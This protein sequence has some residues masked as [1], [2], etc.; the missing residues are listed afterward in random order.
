MMERLRQRR[1]ALEIALAV[2]AIVAIA[3]ALFR[4]ALYEAPKAPAAPVAASA[5][6]EPRSQEEAV[7]VYVAGSVESSDAGTGW[8]TVHVGQH[9]RVDE[10]LR[11]ALN[12]RTDLQLSD[13]SKVS[14][15]E[16]S[17]VTIRELGEKVHRFRVRR[18]RISVDYKPNAQRVL[19]VENE[20]S[21]AVAETSG[22]R[23]TLLSTGTAVA[24]ATEAGAV[25]VKAGG[26][27]VHI[28]EGRQAVVL[29]GKQPSASEPIPVQALLR[30]ANTAPRPESDLCANVEGTAPP[31]SEVLVD[32][33]PAPLSADGRFAVRVSSAKEKRA[34]V[35]VMRDAAGREETRRIPCLA[36]PP[37]EP[38]IR[39]FA[40]RWKRRPTP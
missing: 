34:A 25:D 32:G 16:S 39:D 26:E 9:L 15:S 22:A 17:Q 8:Q 30:A 7:V 33:A 20:G 3:W 18:G 40:I 4:V 24:I 5:V 37:P 19:V 31:G 2:A 35:V 27:A 23:F 13:R 1:T 6:Q 10:S 14:I 38:K 12:A 21:D 29:Q 36:A 28:S 11:T